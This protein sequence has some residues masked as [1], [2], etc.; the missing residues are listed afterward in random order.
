MKNILPFALFLSKEQFVD[1]NY[2]FFLG[3]FIF[4][5]KLA[6]RLIRV[7]S[8]LEGAHQSFSCIGPDK[9][10]DAGERRRVLIKTL[11]IFQSGDGGQSVV[12]LLLHTFPLQS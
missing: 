7:L 3:L 6:E 11:N 1:C 9:W 8:K 2:S 12:L 4:F 10:D 5:I